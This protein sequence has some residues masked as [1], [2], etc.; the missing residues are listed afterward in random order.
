[1]LRALLGFEREVRKAKGPGTHP[2]PRIWG[3]RASLSLDFGVTAGNFR[4]VE[5]GTRF[6]RATWC[7]EG[8]RSAN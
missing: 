4:V 6:E 8:T 7:L 2:P 5:R 3:R 1:M